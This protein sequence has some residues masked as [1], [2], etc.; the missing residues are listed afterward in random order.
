[1]TAPTTH[2]IT[3]ALL[4]IVLLSSVTA[5]AG[6][7]NR[8]VAANNQDN[9]IVLRLVDGSPSQLEVVVDGNVAD[10]ADVSRVDSITLNGGGGDDTFII[11]YAN[12]FFDVR[13]IVNGGANVTATG[14]SIII[15]GLATAAASTYTPGNVEGDG[16]SGVL[17]Y[18]VGSRTHVVEFKG[19]EPVL[20]LVPGTVTV[21]GTNADNAISYIQGA[22]PA[23]GMVTVDGFETY[24]FG[25]K[26]ALTINGNS[27]D[28]VISVD[29]AVVPAGLTAINVNAGSPTASDTVI[30]SGT[31]GADTIGISNLGSDSADVVVNAGPT[32]TLSGVELLRIDGQGGDD[33]LTYT[34]PSPAELTF[35]PGAVPDAAAISGGTQFSSPFLPVTYEDI[36]Q[37]GSLIF[38]GAGGGTS[39]GLDIL[40]TDN[41]DRFILTGAGVVQIVKPSY[42]L[43]VTVPISTPGI[44]YLRLMGRDGDDVFDIPGDHP[45]DPGMDIQGGNPSAS[46]VLNLT[47]A[48]ATNEM[49]TIQRNSANPTEQQV[50]G[51]GAPISVS[52][53]ELIGYTGVGGGDTL[54]IDLGDGFKTAMLQ[55]SEPDYDRVVSSV[56]PAT[57]FSALSTLVIDND[58]VAILTVMTDDLDQAATFRIDGGNDETLIIQGNDADNDDFIVSN[59][60]SGNV[61][62]FD[63]GEAVTITTVNIDGPNDRLVLRPEG[64]DDTVTIDVNGTGLIEVPITVEGGA[65]SDAL[66]ISGTPSVTVNSVAYSAGPAADEGRLTYDTAGID[67]TIDFTGLEPIIDLIPAATLAVNATGADNAINYTQGLNPLNGLVGVDAFETIE[68]ANKAVLTINGKGGSDVINI[69]C[70]IIPP[71][72]TGIN[73][74]GGDPTAS[75]LLIVNARPGMFDPQVVIPLAQGAGSVLN[76]GI[77]PQVNYMGIEEIDLIGQLADADPFGIDGTVGDDVFGYFSGLTPDTGMIVGTMDILGAAFTL[78]NITFSGMQQASVIVINGFGLG[79]QGGTDSFAFFGTDSDDTVTYAGTRLVS[80]ANGQMTANIDPG[81]S[82]SPVPGT[83]TGLAIETRDGDDEVTVTGEPG[84][85]ITVAGGEPSSGSDSLVYITTGPTLL[86]LGAQTVE[87][88][89]IPGMPDLIYSGVEAVH[90]DSLLSGAPLTVEAYDTDD[91]I[92]VTPQAGTPGVNGVIETVA[93]GPTVS[94]AGIP[95]IDIGGGGGLD[96][97]T[98]RGNVL[99]EIMVA[100][101]TVCILPAGSVTYNGPAEPIEALEVH[102]LP[103]PDTFL[104]TQGLIPIFVDGGDPVGSVPGMGD[105]LDVVSVGGA[106]QAGP[107]SDSG[108]FTAPGL[109]AV[110]F[111]HIE[112]LLLNGLPFFVPDQFEPNESISDATVLGSEHKI[113]LRDLSIHDQIADNDYFQITAQDTGKLIINVFFEH[114]LGDIDIDVYDADGDYIAGGY[115]IDDDEQLVIPVVSQERYYLHVRLFFDPDGGGNGYDLE[116]EQFAAPVPDDVMLSPLDDTGRSQYDGVTMI[117]QCSLIIQ[118]DLTGFAAE[119]ILILDAAQAAA[120]NIPG[121]A[122]EVLINGLPVGF[123]TAIPGTAFTLF[124]YTCAPGDLSTTLIPVGGGGGLNIVAAAVRMFDGQV[125]NA[126]GRTQECPPTYLV[127]DRT[128]PQGS[129]P[130]MLSSSD[131]GW[132]DRDNVTYLAQPA[133]QGTSEPGADVFIYAYDVDANETNL[134][135]LAEVLTDGRWEITVEPLEH[136]DPEAEYWIYADYEDLAGNRLGF[137]QARLMGCNQD[138]DLF[139]ISTVTGAAMV[140]PSSLPPSASEVAWDAQ[141]P[142]LYMTTGG[143]GQPDELYSIDPQSGASLGSVTMSPM[144]AGEAMPGMEVVRGKLY[145]VIRTGPFGS[146]SRLVSVDQVTGVIANIGDTGINRPVSALAWDRV[147]KIMYGLSGGSP[148]SELLTIDIATAQASVIGDINIMGTGVEDIGGLAF[149][150]DGLLYAG[151]SGASP[152]NPGDILRVDPATGDAMV[153]GPSGLA[154]VSGLTLV[155]PY[156]PIWI[157]STPPLVPTLRLIENY[158]TCIC[159]GNVIIGQPNLD[160]EVEAE[161][162]HIVE[163]L[164]GTTVADAFVSTGL[165]ARTVLFETG[166]HFVSARVRDAAGHFSAQ[167]DPIEFFVDVTPPDLTCPMDLIVECGDSTDTNDTGVATATDICTNDI[168]IAWSDTF[169]PGSCGG[170]YVIYRMWTATDACG[171]MTNCAQTIQV[172]DTAPP[173]LICPDDV[174][175]LGDTGC[176]A[177]LP[178]L[179]GDATTF[180]ICGAVSLTQDPMP[181]TNLPGPSDYAVTLYATDGCHTSQCTFMVTVRCR[182]IHDYDGDGVSDIATFNEASGTW[183]IYSVALG[184]PILQNGN[185]G[186]PGMI[187]VPGDY[188]GDGVADLAVYR[189]ST[190]EWFIYSLATDTMLAYE[191]VWGY[192]GATPMSGDF[193]GDGIDD[194]AVYDDTIGDWFILTFPA[195]DIIAYEQNWGYAGFR[196]VPGDYNGDGINDLAV[197]E[198]LTGDWYIMEFPSLDVMLYGFNWGFVTYTPVAGDYDGDGISDLTVF[199][200]LSQNWWSWSTPATPGDPAI[201]WYAPWGFLGCV[202][203][204]GDYDGDGIYDR[205]VYYEPSGHW[206]ILGSDGT[207]L[208]GEFLWGGLGFEAVAP[209]Q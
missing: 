140:L 160:F 76:C 46:D 4:S 34:T 156:V 77:L 127:L 45:F 152:T 16:K 113:T 163:I 123:A 129:L 62:I 56:L 170:E 97:L 95:T 92:T 111:D 184:A 154:K 86:D 27:G 117:D 75:D 124:Q 55:D 147:N 205:A 133:F 9:Q 101:D 116:I 15:K 189:V 40:G 48:P 67:M 142:A 151:V 204:P 168:V 35:T 159:N 194:L 61:R 173:L 71:G 2:R 102:G 137:G 143:L 94:Y 109:E 12:G 165:Q 72:L 171:N 69:N 52:G 43:Q 103:G 131:G 24:E 146:P 89:G 122:V 10:A 32:I 39:D 169:A 183:D 23:N 100:S 162:D 20:D 187:A 121:A 1:M 25:A 135:G 155:L 182:T 134:V 11:D 208:L 128:A 83:T 38:A 85:A 5:M 104:V 106:Y 114:L 196:P 209:A 73:V 197:Y 3:H 112:G 115:S 50:I 110:S 99:A 57:R 6:P 26:T 59:D 58:D 88:I 190:G 174:V 63:P 19:L 119:G 191:L 178:D 82:L 21:N 84:L 207:I 149:G 132:S 199:E 164:D 8:V 167:T 31:T 195:G 66:T 161:V 120:G 186:A 138:G 17:T 22:N 96:T 179:T 144:G 105:T 141:N 172:E 64:Q 79:N 157:D 200:G 13:T 98:V 176:V 180:D 201:L 81:T 202:A 107:E 139:D 193:N 49:V 198:Q 148:V 158:D 87:D 108:S 93:A 91:Q 54:T 68:F 42:A 41:D 192:V 130:D 65:G 36:G 118:A 33:A 74:D 177:V 90:L 30:V 150:P 7:A 78:P 51:L 14:D 185:W 80:M 166:H 47:G 18:T 44:T 126:D 153:V 175:L 181:G 145:A 188:D 70:P 37:S 136:G 53:I 125:P 60:G 203:V 29:A 206:W 28:D